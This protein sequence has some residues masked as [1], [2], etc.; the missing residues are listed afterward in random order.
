MELT[1][2]VDFLKTPERYGRLGGRMPHGV[3]LS[4]R[5]DRQ[6]AAREGR[7]RARPTPRSSRSRPRSSSRRS[8]ASAPRACASVRAG[9]CRCALDHLHRRARRDRPFASGLG[10][11]QWVK[12]RAR[13]D[14]RP[15]P[16]RD[17]RLRADGGGRRAGRDQPRRCARLG[18][19]ATRRFDRRVV[20][21]APDRA[22]RAAILR[23]HTQGIP[24]APSVDLDALA[25]TTPGMVGADLANLANEAALLAARRAT[26]RSRWRTSPIRWRR[27][28]SAPRAASSSRP[29]IASAPPTMS[30]ATRSSA[31]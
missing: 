9:P 17:G 6:D 28:C 10:L 2:I 26:S 21:Q 8:S 14:A 20:V 24:L 27:S 15:D 11:G 12:R 30:P 22:G 31:C 19:A 5:R 1:E 3:L 23:V 4:A 13:A 25:A 29:P 7:W 16:D 18:A